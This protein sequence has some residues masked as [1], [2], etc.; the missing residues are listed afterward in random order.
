MNCLDICDL[1]GT[2]DTRDI[3]ITTSRISRAYTNRLIG[4]LQIWSIFIGLG[5]N[6]HCLNA[7]LV[8]G[9]DNTQR[10]FT[11]VCYKDS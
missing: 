4:K 10:Y 8:T 2:Y 7:K 1:S 11:T 3:K 5:I 6:C 9:T